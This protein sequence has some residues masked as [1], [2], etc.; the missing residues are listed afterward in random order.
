MRSKKLSLFLIAAMLIAQL[1]FPIIGIAEGPGE[2]PGP[3][4]EPPSQWDPT[5]TSIISTTPSI[6]PLFEF[7]DG[8]GGP[9]GFYTAGFNAE[10]VDLNTPVEI[11]IQATEKPFMMMNMG[12][13]QSWSYDETS[14]IVTINTKPIDFYHIDQQTGEEFHMP[15]FIVVNFG[16]NPGGEGADQGPPDEAN[17]MW[18]STDA[19]QWEFGPSKDYD[20]D[21]M[22][23]SLVLELTG[24]A[25]TAGFFKM[26]WPTAL[27][28][29]MGLT[30]DTLAGFINGTQASTT[31]ETVEGGVVI[32][33]NVTYTATGL[34]SPRLARA[35]S[36]PSGFKTITVATGKASALSIAQ[37]K[38]SV[39][40]GKAVIISG[41]VN[42]KQARIGVALYRKLKGEKRF[43]RVGV[44][45]TN[46]KG[47]YKF[48]RKAPKTAY[49]KTAR[50]KGG[51]LVYS[52]VI[53]VVV[54]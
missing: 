45:K 50:I 36:T 41:Y 29:K 2:G 49:Y 20:G 33:F 22:P 9:P 16:P 48:T 47:L 43:K 40:K 46:S 8:Q 19:T 37:S 28:N 3:G 7:S 44:T 30:K 23:S 6:T 42:P 26:F 17:G 5:N 21:G 1:A 12:N 32:T 10:A 31:T 35:A 51:K 14:K 15:E 11:K 4:E 52:S 13:L 25:G 54:K 18:M 53:K 38:K 27:L 39:K 24:K 34:P